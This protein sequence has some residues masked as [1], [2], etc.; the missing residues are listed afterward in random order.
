VSGG[1]FLQ[2]VVTGLAAGAVYGLVALG[3]TLV[4]GL[5]RV[6]ALAHGDIVVASV[7]I[8]VL[9]VLGSTPVSRAPS[10]L[11]SIALVVLVLA[12]GCVLSAL[13]YAVAMRPFIGGVRGRSA[14]AVGWVAGAIAA[15]LAI[16]EVCGLVFTRQAYAIPD[17]LR[18]SALTGN[19]VVS[20]PG[21][22]TVPVRTFGV[23]AIG[24]VVAVVTQW[25]LV[26][27][28]LGRALRAASDDPET[29]GLLGVPVE[30]LVLL[31]FV[32]AGLLAGL[33]G[34]LDA[35]G[36]SLSV[37]AGV[38]LGLKGIAAAFIGRL[39]SLRGALV[40][41]VG[42]GLAESLVVAWPPLGAEYADVL[43]LGLL[44]VIL[45]LRP[46][47]LRGRVAEPVE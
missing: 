39:G 32:V 43:P 7:F 19:G 18:L 30:R 6:Y 14:D 36:R 10:A 20:L 9:A 29:A 13:V 1:E 33:A 44:V 40:G 21:G 17:P 5:T 34:L 47:G 27:G 26:R 11:S 3:F 15:G 38:V 28:R 4:Y 46:E 35:P 31:A 41:G 25:L 22:T 37:D 16:R 12:A 23:F 42:L 45:A 2:A 8:G 24:V